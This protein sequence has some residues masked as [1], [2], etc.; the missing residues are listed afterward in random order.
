MADGEGGER[1]KG[2]VRIDRVV[3]RGGDKGRT[4][5]ADGSRVPKDDPRLDAY[6]TVDELNAVV[7]LCVE[8]A[9]GPLAERLAG[10]QHRLFDLGGEL[11][12][13]GGTSGPGDDE[14]ARLEAWADEANAPLPPLT[15]FVLPGGSELAARLHLARTVCRR[16]ERLVVSLHA[17]GGCRGEPLRYLNRLSDLLFVLARAAAVAG[18]GEVLWRPGS[19]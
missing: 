1:A 8:A 3:T 16:A 4:S 6:G 19:A 14:V 5:L 2:P 10:L 18:D 9:E 11:A 15:S 13:P 7:G 12:T 17:A